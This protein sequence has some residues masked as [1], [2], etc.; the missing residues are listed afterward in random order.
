MPE[1]TPDEK[2]QTLRAYT[3]YME[4]NVG[5]DLKARRISATTLCEFT[6]WLTI[7]RPSQEV[8]CIDGATR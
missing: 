5:H 3:E 4:G 6:K 8:Y 1:L 2:K 7:I